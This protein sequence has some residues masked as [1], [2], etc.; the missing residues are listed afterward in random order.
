MSDWFVTHEIR[1]WAKPDRVYA[2]EGEEIRIVSEGANA[3]ICEKRDGERFPVS[4]E[5]LKR[6][7]EKPVIT[8]PKKKNKSLPV[9]AVVPP[10]MF[11]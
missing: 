5:D 1:S 9:K 2:R 7:S 10:L 8:E 6:P 4:K 3:F 11:E